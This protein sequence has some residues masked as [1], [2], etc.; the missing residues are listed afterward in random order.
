MPRET[1][2]F[3]YGQFRE[4][5][6]GLGSVAADIVVRDYKANYAAIKYMGDGQQRPFLNRGMTARELS[7][8]D[9]LRLHGLFR[10]GAYVV[11]PRDRER[12]RSK[13]LFFV[14]PMLHG[15]D[16]AVGPLFTADHFTFCVNHAGGRPLKFHHT[17]YVPVPSLPGR[18]EGVLLHR[19]SPLPTS[20]DLPTSAAALR[21]SGLLDEYVADRHSAVLAE[22]LAR[23]FSPLGRVEESATGGSGQ[24][25]RAR[26][27]RRAAAAKAREAAGMPPRFDDLWRELP[28][29]GLLVIGLPPP[30]PLPGG[31]GR[32]AEADEDAT[33]T[34]VVTDRFRYSAAKQKTVAVFK[35][36][37]AL[38]H[39]DAAIEAKIAE[40]LAHLSWDSMRTQ[41]GYS[42]VN[43]I[44]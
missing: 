21:S 22:M 15:E 4:Y 3:S 44:M 36:A 20:F 7:A 2:R 24:E 23:P 26:R 1:V 19:F 18:P 25:T 33:V 35:V 37:S 32:R 31:R 17:E 6:C 43:L 29:H 30:P 13:Q 39:N 5:Y 12:D 42:D 11:H 9:P 8:D 16:D 38:L 14:H 27:R 34:V 10:H 41:A 40:A 28:I